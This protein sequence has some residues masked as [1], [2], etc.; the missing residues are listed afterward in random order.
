MENNK[1]I[2]TSF[3]S[4]EKD[5][6]GYGNYIDSGLFVKNLPPVTAQVVKYE[7]ETDEKQHEK[8]DNQHL[9]NQGY[10]R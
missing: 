5:L 2:N 9:T 7:K 6:R 10:I 8:S 1:E 3:F 4:N